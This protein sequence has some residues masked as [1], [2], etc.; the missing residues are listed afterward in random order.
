MQIL[1]KPCSKFLNWGKHSAK[2]GIAVELLK[3][4]VNKLYA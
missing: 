2:L 3:Y 1:F 4:T